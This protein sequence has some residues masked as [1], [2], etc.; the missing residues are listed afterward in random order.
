MVERLRLRDSETLH[1]VLSFLHLNKKK[2]NYKKN[3]I[4]IR[5]NFGYP[6][7][8]GAALM[9]SSFVSLYL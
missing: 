9:G 3:Y 1:F 7:M 6:A 4:K 5:E 8:F 2:Y